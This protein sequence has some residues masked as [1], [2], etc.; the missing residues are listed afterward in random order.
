MFGEE[1]GTAGEKFRRVIQE[2][3]P[4][5]LIAGELAASNPKAASFLTPELNLDIDVLRNL[6]KGYNKFN[7]KEVASGP[8][9]VPL[10]NQMLGK[11]FAYRKNNLD[12][13]IDKQG[14]MRYGR[15]DEFNALTLDEQRK[16]FN[17]R[18]IID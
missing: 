18:K 17:A 11:E 15:A 3:K 8:Y 13:V 1:A 10:T 5:A 9:G 16:V 14:F 2:A 7:A 4:Q 12:V 6:N